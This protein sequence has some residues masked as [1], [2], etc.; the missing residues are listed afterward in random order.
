MAG[1]FLTR[2]AIVNTI[3]S[4]ERVNSQQK[5]NGTNNH[6]RAF[7]CQCPDPD[8]GA[9][10][11]VDDERPLPTRQQCDEILKNHKR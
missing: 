2:N 1:K 10:H 5:R 8:C 9:F 6:D 7:A 4:Q 11:T 3:K